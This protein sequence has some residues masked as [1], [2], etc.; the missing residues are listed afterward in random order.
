MASLNDI[1]AWRGDIDNGIAMSIRDP[2]MALVDLTHDGNEAGPAARSRT[3]A[4]TR[5]PATP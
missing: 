2:G 5:T 1:N 4:S 3:S